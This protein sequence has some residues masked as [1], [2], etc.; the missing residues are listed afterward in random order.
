MSSLPST[1]E[2]RWL[3]ETLR[4]YEAEHGVSDDSALLPTL[5][6][7]DTEQR[8][9]QR[10][11]HLIRAQH[12][13]W[14]NALHTWQSQTR[15]VIVLLGI[16]ALLSGFFSATSLINAG[17]QG[18]DGR[19]VNVVWM[20]LALLFVPVFSLLLWLGLTLIQ[21]G[22]GQTPLGKLALWL[23]RHLPGQTPERL[24]LGQALLGL[25]SHH[26]LLGSAMSSLSH[27]LWLLTLLA[28]I[29]GLLLML[30]TQRHVFVWETTIL[31]GNMFVDFVTALG[32][33]PA[34][35]GFAT[36]SMDMIL[37]SGNSQNTQTELARHAWASWLVGC[38][39]VYGFLP[40]LVAFAF[41]F[42]MLRYG[43]GRLRLDMK[44]PGY[45]MLRVRLHQDSQALGVIDP[46][47]ATL[48][49]SRLHPSNAHA[50]DPHL[51]PTLVAF[52][53]GDDIPWPPANAAGLHVFP[54]T[55]SRTE[56]QQL[57]DALQVAP[58]ESLLIAI[59]SRLSPDRG[60]LGFIH[61]L[62]Q[63]SPTPLVW[64]MQDHERSALWRDSL[65]KAGWPNDALLDDAAANIWLRGTAI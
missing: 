19:S 32:S 42:G 12:S 11:E 17:T 43:L 39:A 15:W 45:A 18:V 40:R 30:A 64:L 26:R 58:P 63:H 36:P 16:L 57:L 10:A 3:A 35:L 31:Q 21:G 44:Q 55:D 25:L 38:V 60:S 29:L 47:P 14:I 7:G 62:A 6:T 5:N 24:R 37:A 51:H 61:Q 9:V 53:L 34:L 8:I 49:S 1:F 2:R 41:S 46:A 54:R 56:R 4:R 22:S 28:V 13:H 48:P 65:R 33:L 59:D 50:L 52:E 23:Q 20:L 27:A